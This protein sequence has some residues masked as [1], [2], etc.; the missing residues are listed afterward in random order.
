MA[1]L[2]PTRWQRQP[3]GQVEIDWNHPLA[4]GLTGLWIFNTPLPVN[5]VTGEKSVGTVSNVGV[6]ETGRGVNQTSTGT[7]QLASNVNNLTN[8]KNG[9]LLFVGSGTETINQAKYFLSANSG[10]TYFGIYG[11]NSEFFYYY[12]KVSTQ[13]N[14]PNVTRYDTT[15]NK[16]IL[17]TSDA[18]SVKSYSNG[19]LQHTGSAG[20]STSMAV[21]LYLGASDG[22]SANFQSFCNVVATWNRKLS[23]KESALASTN[24][25]ALLRHL[26]SIAAIDPSSF[27]V[28]GDLSNT[29]NAPDIDFNGLT[30]G[31]GDML[32]ALD[33]TLSA[34]SITF[35]GA[36]GV[37]EA[38]SANVAP[39][40]FLNGVTNSAGTFVA[41]IPSVG[42]ALS[43]LVGVNEP[44]A[45]TL[46]AP[47]V[48]MDGLF[49]VIGS[50]DLPMVSFDVA[51]SEKPSIT[52]NTSAPD[53]EFVGATGVI[54]SF[55]IDVSMN[56]TFNGLVGRIGSFDLNLVPNIAF[57]GASSRIGDIPLSANVN[58]AFDGYVGMVQAFDMTMPAIDVDISAGQSGEE[59][60]NLDM[61]A[62]NIAFTGVNNSTRQL[63]FFNRYTR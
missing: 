1:L 43:G 32:E 24:I 4:K 57:E 28:T 49:G 50:F 61:P 46:I 9:S 27:N 13:Q 42:I 33:S 59:S 62:V 23:D 53:V 41:G 14:S 44:I 17:M 21:P 11:N 29:L 7:L 22:A 58:V 51:L 36:A 35:E 40:L 26:K 10:S 3:Q 56:S 2:L 47:D 45:S 15:K 63:K 55:A 52:V 31:A 30:L 5:L 54:G 60:F 48:E 38:L 8:G 34:P 6:S 18:T 37:Y 16:S 19:I 12:W 39:D 25:Y 20:G